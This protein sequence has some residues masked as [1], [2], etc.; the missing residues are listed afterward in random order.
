MKAS[1]FYFKKMEKI[2]MIKEIKRRTLE[3]MLEK[4]G[5]GFGSELRESMLSVWDVREIL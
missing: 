3:R 5:G 4:H 1:P 2:K